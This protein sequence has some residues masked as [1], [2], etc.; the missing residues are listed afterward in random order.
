MGIPLSCR[1]AHASGAEAAADNDHCQ[2]TA[3][4]SLPVDAHV[5]CTG[6]PLTAAHHFVPH[7]L[8]AMK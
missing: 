7:R 3:A 6:N 8:E 4:P 2:K 5:Q 1:S